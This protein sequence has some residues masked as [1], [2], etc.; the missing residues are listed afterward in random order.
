[1]TAI[2]T[3]DRYVDEFGF[4][5]ASSRASTEGAHQDVNPYYESRD[6]TSQHDYQQGYTAPQPSQSY[7]TLPT[8]VAPASNWTV[9]QS[10]V[11]PSAYQAQTSFGGHGGYG[12]SQYAASQ[13]LYQPLPAISIPELPIP[14][15]N[16]NAFTIPQ[17]A[18][19]T[20]F[21]PKHLYNPND[22]LPF[23]FFQQQQPHH[24]AI[25]LLPPPPTEDDDIQAQRQ[26]LPSRARVNA[27]KALEKAAKAKVRATK[28]EKKAEV[29]LAWEK[30]G[31]IMEVERK[32]DETEK[33]KA[34]R[35]PKLSE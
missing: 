1:M 22:I 2:Q 27:S 32:K 26:R 6:L 25:P 14:N 16:A 9:S 23:S 21:V 31:K 30:N 24:L 10:Q 5:A 7:P 15:S 29:K 33:I 35:K 18:P 8:L 11:A 19:P 4:D 13:Q 28:P 17:V 12:A 20:N 3:Q 34:G